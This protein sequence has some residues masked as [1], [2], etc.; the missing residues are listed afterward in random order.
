MNLT[1]YALMLVKAYNP[2]QY[3]K[4]VE[5][6]KRE[7]FSFLLLTMLFSLIIF[8]L[9]IIP[10]TVT[11]I[12]NIPSTTEQI[13]QLEFNASVDTDHPVTLLA[14]PSIILDLD[15]NETPRGEITL[16]NTGIL[17]P[18][19]LLFGNGII[20]WE[21]VHNLKNQTPT[22]D[23][24]L[25]ALILFLIPSIIFWFFLYSI[26]KISLI[27]L[28][29]IILG[30]CIPR[31]FKHEISFLDV[32]KIGILA[33]PSIFFMGVALFPIGPLFWWGLLLT[34]IFFLF[35]IALLSE[36]KEVHH[37]HQGKV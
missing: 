7:F 14:R 24:A 21:E 9:L 31:I 37:K 2:N 13:N 3:A 6:S 1:D 4:L 33:L 27:F 28:A 36:V 23:H 12:N 15:A 32:V 25:T 29:L 30:Y 26:F 8:V 34:V 19:Y 16:S 20:R 5:R 10:V 35:G 11:Y 22:R 17:Y 18:K